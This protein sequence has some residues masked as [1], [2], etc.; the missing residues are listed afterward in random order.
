MRLL[1]WIRARRRRAIG[2]LVPPFDPTGERLGPAI[3]G[4]RRC[5]GS[6]PPGTTL[7]LNEPGPAGYVLPQA[8]VERIRGGEDLRGR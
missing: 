8:I 3:D 2:G 4:A 1:R 7:V 6:A 5:V